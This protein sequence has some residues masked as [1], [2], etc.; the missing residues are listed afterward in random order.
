MAETVKEEDLRKIW[1]WNATVPESV[2]ACVHDLITERMLLEAPAVCAWDGELTY[3]ELDTLSS[4][5]AYHLVGLGVGPEVIVPLCFE[6]SMWMPV[7]MLGVMKAGGAGCA[8]DITQPRARLEAIMHQAQPHIV[9]SSAANTTL[10]RSLLDDIPIL[11]IEKDGLCQLPPTPP[12]M[13]SVPRTSVGPTNTLYLVFTS[14]STGTPKGVV[15]THSNFSSALFYQTQQ[16]GFKRSSRVLDMASYAFDA[17]WYN[18]LHTLYAGGCLCIPSENERRND[19]TGA[20]RRLKPTFINLTP[21]LCEFLDATSL[22]GLDM[23]EL[24]GEQADA[25]QVSRMREVTSVRFAY[26]PAECSILSTVSGNDASCSNV[27]RGLGIRTWVVNADDPR[28]LVPMGSVGELWIEGPLVGQGYLND[29][30]KTAEAFVENPPWLLQGGPGI[31]GRS[32]RLYRTGDLVRYNADDGSLV[33]AGR[34]DAQVKIRGQR[35]ELGEVEQQILKNLPNA[36]DTQVVAD[37]I[38]PKESDS[39][40][41]VVFVKNTEG[42]KAAIVPLEERLTAALPTYMIPSA[43]IALKEIPMSQTGKTD[44][45]KLRELGATYTLEHIAQINLA[46]GEWRQPETATEKQLQKLWATVLGID[47]GIIGVADSFLRIGGDSIKAM[48]LVAAAREVRR[49]NHKRSYIRITNS[50]SHSPGWSVFNSC[51]CVEA[52]EVM[53]PSGCCR[54]IA[55]VSWN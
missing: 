43:Y 48:R 26:G 16:L 18:A 49:H 32:G 6:K 50:L 47:A 40:T 2:E 55:V 41:L 38:K 17:A 5:L 13:P 15:I 7:A 35:V 27:G 20:I 23:I 21:K 22:Q 8:I 42:I 12:T 54:R 34:K 52:S 28:I 44:R 9:L 4:R 37:V 3:G 25:R 19:L 46:R 39:A 36:V 29:G 14:G 53:R 24:A 33:F 11:A 51:R 31:P 1:S 30:I 10:A 45:K